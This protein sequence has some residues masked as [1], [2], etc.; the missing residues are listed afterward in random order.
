MR[1][2]DDRLFARFVDHSVD[3]LLDGITA[4]KPGKTRR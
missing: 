4:R 2:S 3:M 1:E